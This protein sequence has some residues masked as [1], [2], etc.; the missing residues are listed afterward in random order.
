[1]R[2]WKR[3][4]QQE[5]NSSIFIMQN[6]NLLTSTDKVLTRLPLDKRKAR[7]SR[8]TKGKL[9]NTSIKNRTS[10]AQTLLPGEEENMT[11]SRKVYRYCQIIC[12]TDIYIPEKVEE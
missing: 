9:K 6:T 5:L 8:N 12:P 3:N 11:R 7:F 2:S 10:K 1:M 4:S